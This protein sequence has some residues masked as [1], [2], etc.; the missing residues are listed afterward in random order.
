MDA[1]RA[2]ALFKELEFGRLLRDLQA[3]EVLPESAA[4]AV[5]A[6][7]PEVTGSAPPPPL[8]A[9]VVEVEVLLD[10]GALRDA[11]RALSQ[12]PSGL[13]PVLGEGSP[14]RARVIG[15]AFA[16]GGRAP[17]AR[18]GIAADPRVITSYSIHYTKLYDPASC[19]CGQVS[20]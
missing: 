16:G 11:L 17:T 3:A 5:P 2:R 14:R 10:E 19:R 13:L 1:E 6:P 8:P 7:R 9:A 12:G 20:I 4:P 18:H 15:L